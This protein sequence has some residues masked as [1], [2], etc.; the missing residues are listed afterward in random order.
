MLL[1]AQIAQQLMLDF[2]VDFYK[3]FEFLRQSLLEL[4]IV[5]LSR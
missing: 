5:G 1:D 4:K 3:L 2:R